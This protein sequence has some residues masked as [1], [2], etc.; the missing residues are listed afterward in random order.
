MLANVWS[1]SFIGLV[2]AGAVG[3][4]LSNPLENIV[5]VCSHRFKVRGDRQK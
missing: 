2:R 3:N 1:A 5:V 4:V